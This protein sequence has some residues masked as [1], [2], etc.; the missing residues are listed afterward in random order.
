MYVQTCSLMHRTF[1]TNFKEMAVMGILQ[2]KQLHYSSYDL[3]KGL[4]LI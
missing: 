1:N 3:L 2:C 4:Y